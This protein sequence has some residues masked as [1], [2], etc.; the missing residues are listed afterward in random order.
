MVG[1]GPTQPDV[2]S[3][4]VVYS[5]PRIA[6]VPFRYDFQGRTKGVGGDPLRVTAFHI[7]R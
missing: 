4:Y 3:R 7:G 1:P 6:G 5:A 2:L